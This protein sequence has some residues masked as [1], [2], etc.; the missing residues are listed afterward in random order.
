MAAASIPAPGR[1]AP[2]ICWQRS[3]MFS[4][5]ITGWYSTITA[6]GLS[7]SSTRASP[8]KNSCDQGTSHTHRG[9]S[10]MKR[11]HA[12]R[13]YVLLL[14]GA[15]GAFPDECHAQLPQS[16]LDRILPLGGEAG[17]TVVLDI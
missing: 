14:L 5:S 15:L 4:G 17:S 12:G 1:S 7:R 3:I 8:S 10:E 2:R 11:H 16:R 13:C 6:A 9:K